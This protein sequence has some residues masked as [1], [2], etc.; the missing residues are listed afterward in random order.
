M[1]SEEF[2]PLLSVWNGRRRIARTAKTPAEE[3]SRALQSFRYD[4]LDPHLHEVGKKFADLAELVAVIPP[5]P[6]ACDARPWQEV[7]A[8]L[9]SLLMARNAAIKAMV[10]SADK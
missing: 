7:R 8:S 2:N 4:H 6:H 10:L 9:R 1:P 3:V 5:L